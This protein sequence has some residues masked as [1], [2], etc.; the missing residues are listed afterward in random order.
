MRKVQ[1]TI[2]CYPE[3]GKT[4]LIP[5]G[6]LCWAVKVSRENSHQVF[7]EDCFKSAGAYL[8]LADTDDGRKEVY[9]GESHIVKGRF[10]SHQGKNPP[11]KWNEAI[12]FLNSTRLP[13]S[14]NE[15]NNI[16]LGLYD[17]LVAANRY[18]MPPNVQHPNRWSVP[19][20]DLI[21]RLV[22]EMIAMTPFLGYPKLFTPL[23]AQVS[24]CE[25]TTDGRMLARSHG[26][27]EKRNE[28]CVSGGGQCRN[29]KR[30]APSF[31]FSMAGVHEGAELFFIEGG[32]RVLARGKNQVEFRGELY[33]LTGFVKKFIPDNKRN[34]KDA[35]QGP[36]YFTYQGEL[37]TKLREK[38]E[39]KLRVFV[40][41][42]ENATGGGISRGVSGKEKDVCA[43]GQNKTQLAKGI[44]MR[45][46]GRVGASGGICQYFTRFKP[47]P[48]HGKWRMPLAD[49]GIKFDKDDFVI[50]WR[51]AR[52][53]T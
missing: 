42:S 32:Q 1:Y 12:V 13:W 43:S 3:L 35:Y 11:V 21:D 53:G 38:R 34:R 52:L 24:P 36:K 29:A 39:T 46:D 14:K 5:S 40:S 22:D 20:Q 45:V 33:S 2:K 4:E 31:N 17:K 18:K 9:V 49:I 47:C 48:K 15:I 6:G 23:R 37:L 19:D 26:A 7:R 16:Q 8:L 27:T 10:A 25:I 50:D 28:A 41:P 51:V 30:I 44:A